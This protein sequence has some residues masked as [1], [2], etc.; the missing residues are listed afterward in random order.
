MKKIGLISALLVSLSVQGYAQAQTDDANSRNS[1]YFGVEAGVV[2]VSNISSYITSSNSTYML[3][4]VGGSIS[5]SY[6]TGVAH[7]R[8]YGGAFINENM[9]IE[10][11]GLAV[12]TIKTSYSGRS[13]SGVAYTA[14][15]DYSTQIYDFVGTFRGDK[16]GPF[17]HMILK[18]GAHYGIVSETA[19]FSVSG[20][21]YTASAS[22]SGWG[23]MVGFA[24]DKQFG[25]DVDWRVSYS[26]YSGIAGLSASAYIINSGVV[27]KF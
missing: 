15:D 14:T 20:T 26:Y 2:N 9:G 16:N 4:K 7:A 8:I 1:K 23:P 13:S 12:D 17:E 21:T 24:Y 22:K 27:F 19:S 25:K 5:A 11:G 18:L 10:I 3:S 6:S